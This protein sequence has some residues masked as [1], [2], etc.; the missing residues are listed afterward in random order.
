[1]NNKDCISITDGDESYYN[2]TY[3][4]VLKNSIRTTLEVEKVEAN[5]VY[6]DALLCFLYLV[7]AIFSGGDQYYCGLFISG[8]CTAVFYLPLSCK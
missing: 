7:F 5:L 6:V 2:R 3:I 1:M 8:T 4:E